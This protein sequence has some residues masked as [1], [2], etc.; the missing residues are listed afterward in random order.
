M[1][2]ENPGAAVRYASFTLRH[3][4][5][6]TTPLPA[7]AAT[8]LSEWQLRRA[9]LVAWGSDDDDSFLARDGDRA[10]RISAWFAAVVDRAKKRKASRG[11]FGDVVGVDVVVS[12]A[13]VERVLGRYDVVTG[14]F[15]VGEV[16]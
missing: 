3:A 1:F 4:D 7:Q 15:V 12:A 16:E 11:E 8:G 9:F 10:D 2:A 6:T 14:R 5:G 13:G